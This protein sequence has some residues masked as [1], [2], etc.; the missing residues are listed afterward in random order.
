MLST[1][2]VSSSLVSDSR[3]AASF[4]SLPPPLMTAILLLLPVDTRL[5]C[6]EVQRAW[7]A[8]LEDTV[9]WECI[10][11]SELARAR[12]R[13]A[14]FVAAVAK[15]GG[16]LRE[17]DL[18]GQYG[19]RLTH[20]S[21]MEA[22][23]ANSLTLRR[24][25]MCDGYGD[26]MSRNVV[27]ELCGAA[28]GLQ[29][30]E[31]C[32]SCLSTEARAL[33]HREPPFGALNMFGLKVRFAEGNDNTLFLSFTADLTFHGACLHELEL[34]SALMPG[35]AAWNA[36]ANAAI[37][38]HLT[39]LTVS[40]SPLGPWCVPGLV[41][42]LREGS[43]SSLELGGTFFGNG[44]F[45]DAETEPSLSAALLA[46]STLTGL[47]LLHVDVWNP[48]RNCIVDALVRHPTLV[49]LKLHFQ[50]GDDAQLRL[51]AG[52]SLGRLVAVNS[53]ALAW[54][55][56]SGCALGDDGLRPLFAALPTN[57][58]LISLSASRNGIS[59]AFAPV[60]LASVRA[61]RS[62]RYLFIDGPE[63]VD[64]D[65]GSIA[66]LREAEAVVRPRS[67]INQCGL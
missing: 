20:A 47:T 7:R 36:L 29:T 23:A 2:L 14:L 42:L 10:T 58:H 25:R 59:A 63:N 30:L 40:N 54:L 17:L 37:S 35:H 49:N 44:P 28:P 21:L 3:S 38:V 31:T 60:V 27:A 67:A 1:N 55:S 12:F 52:A 32:V 50:L 57:T 26:D 43:I 64:E 45:I 62:L 16:Q 48:P 5:R 4:H 33:L 18:R 15:A 65:Q 51:L 6:S 9:F 19:P 46:N 13:V 56:V 34:D 8:L 61:N 53:T 22:L 24:L 39:Q 11:F 41:R 66:E